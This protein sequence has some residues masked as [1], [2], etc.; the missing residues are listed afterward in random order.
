M[1]DKFPWLKVEQV[2][3][4]KMWMEFKKVTRYKKRLLNL[5]VVCTTA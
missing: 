3:Y 5:Y 1:L 4:K 2:Y